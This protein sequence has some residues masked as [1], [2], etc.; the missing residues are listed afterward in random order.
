NIVIKN[1]PNGES[2][3]QE[4]INRYVS[5]AKFLRALSYFH[6]VRNWGA[7]PLRTELN[8]EDLAL[9][10]SSAEEVYALILAD[11]EEA[12]TLLPE[13]QELLGRPTRFAAKVWLVDVQ[14]QLERYADARAKAQEV[15]GSGKHALVSV[16]GRDDFQ[17]IFGPEV[18]TTPEEIFSLKFVR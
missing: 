7:I 4:D 17:K 15:M 13:D 1:A 5:E 11:L 3:S 9:P 6:L 12:E 8:M 16:S 14:L 10:K 2:I 18:I